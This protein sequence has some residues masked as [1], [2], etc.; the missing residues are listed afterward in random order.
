[1]KKIKF[2]GL[3]EAETNKQKVMNQNAHI[4][5]PKVGQEESYATITTFCL[6]K[7][8]YKKVARLAKKY[9][10]SKSA[11]IRILLENTEI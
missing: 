1:M 11:V 8:Y 3:M 5:F 7:Q 2:K 9:G 6:T 10:I 4:V